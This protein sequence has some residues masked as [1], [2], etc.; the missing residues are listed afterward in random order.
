MDPVVLVLMVLIQHLYAPDSLHRTAEEVSFNIAYRWFLSYR[1]Q[2]DTPHFTALSYNFRHRFTSETVDQIFKWILMEMVEAGYVAPGVIFVDGTHIK[3]N[4]NTKKAV[5]KEVPVAAKRYAEELM[6]EV[7]ADREAHGKKPLASDDD[8]DNDE[9]NPP[10]PPKKKKDNTCKQ[11]LKKRKKEARKTVTVSTTDPNCGLFVKGDHK[12]QMA[13]EAQTACYVHG[14]F[15]M[16]KSLPAISMT[17]FPLTICTN[18]SQ[19]NLRMSTPS[20][21]TAPIRLPT[22]VSWYS[23]M[24]R[25]YPQHTC[26]PER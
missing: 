21:Q 12:R 2:E 11:K 17:A 3:A 22:S 14:V 4:T 1:L 13:Y 8:D 18:E 20:W 6:Q 15:W 9:Q 19:R 16:W 5:K 10:A 24:V 7:N 26:V 23:V 25:F